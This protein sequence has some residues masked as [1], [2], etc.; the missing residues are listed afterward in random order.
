M[1]EL[2]ISG[3]KIAIATAEDASIWQQFLEAFKGCYVVKKFDLGQNPLGTRGIEILVRVYAQSELDYFVESHENPCLERLENQI[4]SLQT[5]NGRAENAKPRSFTKVEGGKKQSS[6]HSKSNS[7][8]VYE[9][10]LFECSLYPL[11]ER[12]TSV[13]KPLIIP[14]TDKSPST[15]SEVKN[16]ACTRSLRSIPYLGL[17]NIDLTDASVVLLATLVTMHRTPEQLLYFLPSGKSMAIP[18]KAG[19]CNGLF[20]LPNQNIRSLGRQLLEMAEKM[21]SMVVDADIDGMTSPQSPLALHIPLSTNDVKQRQSLKK[22]QVDYARLLKRVRLDSLREDGVHS[23]EIWSVAL[24]MMLMSRALLLEDIDRQASKTQGTSDDHGVNDQSMI[25]TPSTR[26]ATPEGI[27]EYEDRENL[28]E[29]TSTKISDNFGSSQQLIAGF[30][31]NFSRSDVSNLLPNHEYTTPVLKRDVA[32]STPQMTR[33][34]GSGTSGRTHQSGCSMNH[35]GTQQQKSNWRF[36]LPVSIWRRI[37]ADA[38]GADG[39]LTHEQQLRVIHYAVDWNSIEH[40]LAI[41]G[42]PD[43]QQIWKILDSVSCLTYSPSI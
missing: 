41:K 25:A 38:V 5:S 8:K 43:H 9:R 12:L 16:F 40:H 2:D 26:A 7:N 13:V 4:R 42:Y 27:V 23:V 37:I 20:W 22:H 39:I 11:I 24:R 35:L 29:I 33:T 15:V 28:S 18:D 34:T 3:N 30:N 31:P 10:R 21:R 36:C 17:S 32:L 6:R 1:H 19:C 14:M